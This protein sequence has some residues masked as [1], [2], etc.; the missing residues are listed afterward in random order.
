MKKAVLA[1]LFLCLASALP[2][3]AAQGPYLGIAGGLAVV[4][5]SDID[6]LP[7]IDDVN[8]EFD[9]GAGFN[10]T[11][12]L[13]FD[14]LR[15]E[16]EFGL[17]NADIDNLEGGGVDGDITTMSYMVNGY[18]DWKIAAPVTPFI[19]VGLGLIDADFEVHGQ[20]GQDTNF[21]YQVTGGVTTNL[22]KFLDLDIYYRYQGA[23]DFKDNGAKMSYD[24]SLIF[25]GLRYNF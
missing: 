20:K 6:N 16:V 8:A 10:V 7:G 9:V 25:A 15:F 3:A 2:A 13:R 14:Q 11:A 21:G 18:Y 24:A 4:H 1:A 22:N 19:G 23:P 5:D 12:G 17:N